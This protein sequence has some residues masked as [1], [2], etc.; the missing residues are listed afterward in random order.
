MDTG[1]YVGVNTLHFR[2]TDC[3]L[4]NQDIIGNFVLQLFPIPVPER[5]TRFTTYTLH[6]FIHFALI[7]KYQYYLGW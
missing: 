7:H 3:H 4:N 6:Y 5:S 2:S 1:N